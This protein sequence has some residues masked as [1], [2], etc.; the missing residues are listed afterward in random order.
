[1][2]SSVN[3]DLDSQAKAY[4]RGEL[5]KYLIDDGYKPDGFFT[6]TDENA[7]PIYWKARLIH[8]SKRK[9]VRAFARN[10]GR[11]CDR[12]KKPY[13]GQFMPCEPSNAWQAVYPQGSGKKPLYPLD[14]LPIDLEQEVV[15]VEGENKVDALEKLG[16]AATTSGSSM[17]T[18]LAYRL[19]QQIV[20]Q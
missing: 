12:T 14:K 2:N 5:V 17:D 1:M 7:T 19:F 20:F 6:Y 11:I 16:I 13:D 9:Q 3:L 15:V 18:F 8:T 10:D 4:A